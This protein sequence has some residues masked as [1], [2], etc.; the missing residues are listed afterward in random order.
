MMGRGRRRGG[1]GVSRQGLGSQAP[2]GSFFGVRKVGWRQETQRI[3]RCA[4]NQKVRTFQNMILHSRHT[5]SNTKFEPKRQSGNERSLSFGM[6]KAFLSRL[7][8]DLCLMRR[9][10]KSTKPG[11][12]ALELSKPKASFGDDQPK[13]GRD[14]AECSWIFCR[15]SSFTFPSRPHFLNPPFRK[16]EFRALARP[17]RL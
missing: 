14:L 1:G 15:L 11:N 13:N 7:V 5:R 12:K 4:E 3:K 9:R 17:A 10:K 6:G 8:S 16:I 2:A